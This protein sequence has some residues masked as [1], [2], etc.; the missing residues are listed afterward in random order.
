MIEDIDHSNDVDISDH[1]AALENVIA[2]D[3]AKDV[4]AKPPVTDAP[5]SAARPKCV[6]PAQWA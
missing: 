1:L 5:S 4:P 3:L 6:A 2:K